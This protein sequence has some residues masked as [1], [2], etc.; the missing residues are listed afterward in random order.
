MRHGQG[1]PDVTP[2]QQPALPFVAFGLA[3]PREKLIHVLHARIEVMLEAGFMRELRELL[4]DGLGDAAALQSLGYK[5]MRPAL[6][7][8]TVFAANVELWKRDTRRYAKR[9]MTWFRHQLQV[10]WIEM[11][12]LEPAQAAQRIARQYS[13]YI[14]NTVPLHHA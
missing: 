3:L 11:E 12:A 2:D 4:E 7:D 10:Q 14:A 1:I 9:Q 8:E 6:E 13:T 5:Q